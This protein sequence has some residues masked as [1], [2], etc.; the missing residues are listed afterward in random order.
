MHIVSDS[1]I[2]PACIILTCL[3]IHNSPSSLCLV[4]MASDSTSS[5]SSS[6]TATATD[7]SDT[8]TIAASVQ[9]LYLY[10]GLSNGVMHRASIDST[11]G[12]ISDIR[13]RF[14]GAKPVKLFNISH[15]QVCYIYIICICICMFVYPDIDMYTHY[16]SSAACT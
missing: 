7:A 6:A 12:A 3:M 4:E 2:M 13:Q 15:G 16:H 1:Q 10:V 11:S 8:S 14:L 5:S 9:H